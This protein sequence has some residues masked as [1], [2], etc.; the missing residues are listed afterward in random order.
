MRKEKPADPV[1]TDP[2]VNTN[3]N[4]GHIW[5]MKENR[6]DNILRYMVCVCI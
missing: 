2:S 6:C 5:I 1:E 3:N 4:Y